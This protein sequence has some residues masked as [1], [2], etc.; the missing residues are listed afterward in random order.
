MSRAFLTTP[1]KQSYRI[2]SSF[3]PRRLHPVT[4]RISPHNG[5]DYATPIGTDLLSISDG[6]VTRIGDHPIAGKHITIQ[7]TDK[8][9]SRYLHLNKI[10]VKQGQ[11][12]SMGEV[13][14]RS[15][16]TG[17][18]TG[19]HLHFELHA[20]SRPVDFKQYPL[21]EGRQLD[22]TQMIAFRQLMTVYLVR[23]DIPAEKLPVG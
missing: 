1:L 20:Q 22:E 21:P 9:S 15:G 5:T 19:P 6:V 2:S 23:M 17:R 3:N 7:Y 14:G 16:K 4:G 11:R 10:L 8:Y 18:V 13:V 12:V